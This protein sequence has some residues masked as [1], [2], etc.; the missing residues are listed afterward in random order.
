MLLN[1]RVYAIAPDPDSRQS[2]DDEG[3]EPPHLTGPPGTHGTN[4]TLLPS[5]EHEA[6]DAEPSDHAGGSTAAIS[7]V[8]ASERGDHDTPGAPTSTCWTCGVG[9]FWLSVHGQWVCA[10]CHPPG[11]EDLVAERLQ[12]A[13]EEARDEGQ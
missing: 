5:E 2:D 10:T 8:R 13:E 4:G 12:L 9:R 11:S 1:T 3:P 7:D 6:D